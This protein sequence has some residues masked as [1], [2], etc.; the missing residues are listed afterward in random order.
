MKRDEILFRS[1]GSA[2][3][4]LL[5]GALLFPAVPAT[6]QTA[7]EDQPEGVQEI[8]VTARR[9]AENLQTTGA[10]ITAFTSD[11]LEAL[12][13]NSASDIAK[14]TP[15]LEFK[16]R[17]GAASQGLAIK[18]RG[19]GVSDVDF[20]ASDPSVAVYIDGIFQARAF[21]PQFELFDLER[22]EVLRG[23]QGTLYGKNSLG[24]AVNIVT[25]K[26]DGKANAAVDA[27]LGN[28]G[29]LNF[30]GRGST[31][32][33]DDK[34]FASIAVVSHTRE[35]FYRN[36]VASG[37]DPANENLQAVRGA[38]RW[39]P[40]SSVTVDLTADYSRQRQHG[41]G[42]FA[43]AISPGGLA[44]NALIAAGFKPADYVVGLNPSPGRLR[45]GA[46]LDYG[47]GTGNFLP[48]NR[49]AR[50]RSL[51][52]A[53]FRGVSLTIATDLSPTT[54]LRSFSSYR[55]F[56]R[57]LSHDV[58]GTPAQIIDQIKSDKGNQLTQEIQLNTQMFDDKINL[59]LGGFVLHEDLSEDQSNTFVLGLANTTPALRAISPH[60][61]REYE[62]LSVAGFGHAIVNLSDALR[63]TA[64]IRYSWER[65]KAF[66]RSGQLQTEGVFQTLVARKTRS[67][68]SITPKLGVEYELNHNLF[69]YATISKGYASGGF[70]PRINTA[71]AG[72]ESYDPESLW[73]YEVGAKA[74]LFDRKLRFNVAAFRMDYDNIVVQSFGAAPAGT[75]IG[76]FTR[77][78]GKAR[79]QGI[80]VDFEFRPIHSLTISGGLGLLRQKFLDFG[81]DANGNP[82]D[83]KVA[84]F[85]DAP[86][87]SASAA[88]EY[89]VPLDERSGTLTVGGD[90]SYRGRNYFD[91]S[92]SPVS[93]QDPYSLFGARISYKLPNGK[94]SLSLFGE[95]LSNKVYAVRTINLL[96]S[97]FGMAGALFGPPRTWGIKVGQKF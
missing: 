92:N 5:A 38:L 35:G 68:E 20:L 40:S 76:F 58:D 84:H 39:V 45:N 78:A 87:Q 95:N 60:T 48:P 55:V 46:A 49:G 10:S 4:M 9:V 1:V 30:S 85:F 62:N 42:F 11:K 61:L 3:R 64:G 32:L 6:A 22:V 59:V 43:V 63:V 36:Q 44:S 86:A 56:D 67:F 18:I 73:S 97:G 90:W 89:T 69:T 93:S 57:F 2:R 83:P 27:T 29:R 65:K 33:I 12:N 52:N 31:V 17:G 37:L 21:G 81:I 66:Y 82:I 7:S 94:T 96:A 25:R 23:P 51:D 8:V 72:I 50:G 13:I 79:V 88:F 77:N 47:A 41:Q 70:A 80:E 34:L 15:N 91:N 19:I 75:A 28:Y 24:G 14:F 74:T 16:T 54:T 53:N 71:A 26:P